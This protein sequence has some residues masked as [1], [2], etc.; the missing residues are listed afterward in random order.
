MSSTTLEHVSLYYRDGRSDKVYHA[1]IVE[2]G[3]GACTVDV[4]WGR[5]GQGLQAGTKTAR[6]VPAAKAKAIFDK[7]VAEKMAKGYTVDESGVAY[8]RSK[9]EG[10]ATGVAPQLLEPIDEAGAAAFIANPD[11][12]AQE[13]HDGRRVLV[14]VA[15]DGVRGINRRGLVVTLPPM[16]EAAA[17]NIYRAI[18]RNAFLIDG[19]LLGNEVVAFDL[20]RL[21]GVPLEGVGYESRLAVLETLTRESPPYGIRQTVTV[22]GA[23]KAALV[24]RLRAERA[25]GV[26]FKHRASLQQPGRGRAGDI[27]THLKYKFYDTASFIVTG[28]NDKRSVAIAVVDAGRQIAVGNVTIPPSADVPEAG[29]VIEVRY[30]YAFPGGSV[31][32]PTFIAVR[33]DVAHEECV[34]AQLKFR[35]AVGPDDDPE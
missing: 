11:Y 4:A 24:E 2:A 31:Y 12:L 26:V 17:V 3:E 22:C 9:D 15:E 10:R 25:E 33:N 1:A 8:T 32:Q 5:R 13:K 16:V 35:Q 29:A 7:V 27:N 23:D 14:S 6:P 28:Q 21:Q 34:A 19:E 18:G 30:L 20:L